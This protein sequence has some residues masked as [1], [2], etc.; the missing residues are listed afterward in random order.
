MT[1]RRT[2]HPRPAWRGTVSAAALSLLPIIGLGGTSLA[3]LPAA[4]TV[5]APSLPDSQI[6]KLLQDAD[7]A[8]KSGN[9]N[10]ALIHLRNAVRLAPQNGA[11]RARMAEVILAAGDFVS[12]ERELRQAM[13]DG[14]PSDVIVPLLLQAM[15][16]RGEVTALL[17][18]YPDPGNAPNP[19]AADILRFRAIAFQEMGKPSEANA[20]MNRSL[21]LRRD[22]A[23]IAT[24]AQLARQQ[25][26]LT[27]ANG[28][29][30][31]ALK[32]QPENANALL[33]KVALL[34]Q[35]GDAP[36]ALALLD[37]MINKAPRSVA[38]PAV[39]IEV[40][41]G[42]NRDAEAKAAVDKLLADNPTMPFGIFY[43]AVLLSRARDFTGAW[44]IA[45]GLSTDFV[46]SQR[47]IW[48]TVATLAIA[49][50]NLETG[51]AYL[52]AFVSKYPDAVPQRT[53]LA[54][55]RLRQ[56]NPQQALQVLEPVKDSSEP[57]VNVVLAQVYL[58]LARYADAISAFEKANVRDG[59]ND[60]LKRQLAVSEFVTGRADEGIQGLK[61]IAE[62]DPGNPDSVAPF[63]AAL[64]Q[65]GRID[66]AILAV[67]RMIGVN[68]KIP[69]P[70]FYRGQLLMA[71]GDL[72][73]A[74]AEYT[75][76]LAADPKF[77]PSLYYRAVVSRRRGDLGPAEADLKKIVEIDPKN[78]TAYI[79]QAE[80]AADYGRDDEVKQILEQAA[81]VASGDLSP[82]FALANYHFRRG[83]LAAAQ[84]VVN[85]LLEVSRD[86]AEGLVLLGQLYNARNEREDALNTF[87]RVATLNPQSA[88]AQLLLG[89]ALEA[90]GNLPGAEAA[91][92][93]A[94][95]LTPASAQVRGVHVGFLA[96][97]D[98]ANDALAA[99]RDYVRTNP[100]PAADLL[101][102]NTFVR[103]R[104]LTE[105]E[106]TLTK[107]LATTPSASTAV[108]L[109]RVIAASGNKNKA[110]G[111]YAAW[112]AKNPN[113]TAV[114]QEYATLLLGAGKTADA[115]REYETVLK[116]L[117]DDPVS[118]NNLAW[119]I[120]K[121]Q[122]ARALELAAKSVRILP[123]SAEMIDTLG[124]MKIQ[125]SDQAGG[126]ALLQQAY[127]LAKNNP[128]IGYHL[129]IALDK[130]G[131][132]QEA[133]TL[134]QSVLTNSPNFDG[135]AEAKQMVARW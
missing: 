133:K 14:G 108:Q 98:R 74:V 119:I 45:Q 56:N 44:R 47:D 110:I 97:H 99:A 92:K 23:G 40:L 128:Q 93:K 135:A 85:N 81:R 33:L 83:D 72:A 35:G 104:R 89:A 126:L 120:Q 68:D 21:A 61:G 31:E 118:L 113:D 79:K 91:L 42:M 29:I 15:L 134:L 131:K 7:A 94:I 5:S 88:T 86:N 11:V 78:T 36:G 124:W 57:Q 13:A 41:I 106:A 34:R 96:S 122:P 46:Q 9:P 100:G 102:A 101:L 43:R 64:M 25:G 10:L 18:Q 51:S 103:L 30:A 130:T 2:S 80:I 112:I 54:S 32:L 55:I 117:P 69:L 67:D 77:L 82:Q 73:G 71:R 50:N 17:Q 114:R 59:D 27:R 6:S 125:G 65:T 28:L 60:F 66:E 84:V 62:R 1:S 52:T 49:G 8:V 111:Q 4:N 48:A 115:R 53:L 38:L 20:A 22:F 26:D 70:R 90:T 63:V 58:R 87:R 3:A 107:R 121:D 39:R 24:S 12:A 129:A 109:G 76:S 19:L 127:D 132:R 116:Q 123:R 16:A 95:D 75:R 105:A 37:E